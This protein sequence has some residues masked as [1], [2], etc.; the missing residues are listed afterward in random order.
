M[1][2]LGILASHQG[3]NFQAIIDACN[4]GRLRAKPVLAI[5]NNSRSTALKRAQKAGI[6]TRH[7]SLQT[8][9]Q[10]EA[11]DRAI[12]DCLLEAD[13]KLV[14]TAGYLKK[15][16]PMTLKKYHRRIVN[17]HPSLLPRYGGQGMYGMNIHRRV[18]ENRDPE[19]GITIHWVDA[20][21]DTGPIIKQQVIPVN[22]NDTPESLAARILIKEHELLINTLQQLTD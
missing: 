16:G 19:T 12:L 3:T 4:T 2:N 8:H 15:L 13:V 7:L 11:L 21:Y 5:S 17:V 18:I 9:P 20:D 10:P 1:I 6:I 14:I 22:N